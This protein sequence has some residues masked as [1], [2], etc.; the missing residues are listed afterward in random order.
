ML[1]AFLLLIPFQQVKKLPLATKKK[2]NPQDFS[3]KPL[4]IYIYMLESAKQVN[5][6]FSKCSGLF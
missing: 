3:F 2:K 5:R 4:K 1:D 6:D